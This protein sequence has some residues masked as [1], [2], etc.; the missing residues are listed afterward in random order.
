MRL[1]LTTRPLALFG[2]M[3]VIALIVTFPMRLALALTGLGDAGLSARSAVGPVWFATLREVHFGAVELGDVRA[4][5][6]PWHLFVGRARVDLA[7]PTPVVGEALRG[8]IS[9]SRHSIGLDDVTAGVAAG[10]IFAPLPVTRLDLAD[11]TVRFDN[12]SC[13]QAE[14][15]VKAELGSGIADVALAQGMSGAA[16]CQGG[17]LLIPLASASGNE[18]VRLTIMGDGRYRAE[19]TVATADPV[20]T[21]RLTASGFQPE[22]DGY[23]LSVEGR[24]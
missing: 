2:A 24:F 11:L 21:Q 23:R 6:S 13:T 5:L 9:V 12:G 14:G 16:K 7:G 18:K 20:V 1:R 8:G 4:G 22:G 10:D 15:R 3:R 17:A 19:L